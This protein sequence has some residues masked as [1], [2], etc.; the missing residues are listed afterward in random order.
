MTTTDTAPIL[1]TRLRNGLTVLA[2]GDGNAKHFVNRTSAHAALAIV[3]TQDPHAY[4][5][6]NRPYYV[7]LTKQTT[8]QTRA[9]DVTSP[10]SPLLSAY[11][12][13]RWYALNAR[14][15]PAG[16]SDACRRGYADAEMEMG[17][18]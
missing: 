2:H 5:W 11:E 4:V 16:A 8:S 10:H 14:S 9:E 7:V 17:T 15:L 3:R 1:W 6:G 13:G 18:P 12:A